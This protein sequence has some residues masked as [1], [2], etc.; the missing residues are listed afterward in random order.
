MAKAKEFFRWRRKSDGLFFGTRT[1][2]RPVSSNGKFYAEEWRARRAL[3]LAARNAPGSVRPEDFELV[4][5]RVTE[6]GHAE[7][8]GAA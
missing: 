7:T 5:Y 6:I 1:W 4:R 8:A 3:E 2:R